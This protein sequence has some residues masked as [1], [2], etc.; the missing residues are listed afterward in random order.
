[1]FA[2]DQ[3]IFVLEIFSESLFAVR[4]PITLVILQLTQFVTF[5]NCCRSEPKLYHQ[6][7][8]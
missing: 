8:V 5:P 1:M 7:K 3:R 2:C 4:Q 6:R